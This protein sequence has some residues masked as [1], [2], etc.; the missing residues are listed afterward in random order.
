MLI[1]SILR[2]KTALAL[3]RSCNFSRAKI[4]RTNTVARHVLLHTLLQYQPR[5]CQDA[6][7]MIVAQIHYIIQVIVRTSQKFKNSELK[8]SWRSRSMTSIFNTSQDHRISQDLCFEQIWW[9]QFKSVMSYHADKKKFT[10]GQTDR[11]NNNTPLSWNFERPRGKNDLLTIE[12]HVY[13]FHE[14]INIYNNQGSHWLISS[15]KKLLTIFSKA[16][17]WMKR[18]AAVFVFRSK[19]HYT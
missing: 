13:I 5:D 4:E 19:L 12:S 10:D 14:K 2:W 1:R 8:L 9:F 3:K 17:S 7:L 11:G 6:Y 15:W 16:F 18:F